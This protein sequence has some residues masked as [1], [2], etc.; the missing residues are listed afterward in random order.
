MP[1]SPAFAPL[2]L[3]SEEQAEVK[4]N[5]R[6]L[7]EAYK[8]RIRN[9]QD[10]SDDEISIIEPDPLVPMPKKHHNFCM[11]CKKP[12][13]CFMTHIESKEHRV[14]IRRDPTYE[15]ID[16]IIAIL[17]ERDLTKMSQRKFTLVEL[18][19]KKSSLVG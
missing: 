18:I 5:K 11:V 7:K 2:F 10:V 3:T 8:R 13:E 12:F 6:A 14:T 9:R 4:A 17:N 16:E 15:E 19:K 1:T